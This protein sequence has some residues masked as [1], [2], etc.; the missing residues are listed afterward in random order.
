M[1]LPKDVIKNFIV[2]GKPVP[3][4]WGQAIQTRI[5]VQE[6]RYFQD[7]IFSERFRQGSLYDPK[8]TGIN[9]Q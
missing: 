7:R 9:P 4:T 8:V 6:G 1:P 2:D 5:S 3:Q